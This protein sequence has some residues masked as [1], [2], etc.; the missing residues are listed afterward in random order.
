MENNLNNLPKFYKG[1][2]V[3]YKPHATF[4]IEFTQVKPDTVLT[5]SSDTPYKTDFKGQVFWEVDEY[6][7]TIFNEDSLI[8]LND[9]TLPLM[10]FEQIKEKEKKEILILN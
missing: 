2:K 5:I 1:Q 7:D 6:Y 10:T 3:A 9:A 4:G 8:P